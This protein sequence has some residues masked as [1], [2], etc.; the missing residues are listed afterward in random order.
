MWKFYYIIFVWWVVY[1][2]DSVVFL[3]IIIMGMDVFIFYMFFVKD[4]DKKK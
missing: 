1:V 3:L 2:W 4:K